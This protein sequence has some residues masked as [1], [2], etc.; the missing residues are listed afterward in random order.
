[1]KNNS[2]GVVGGGGPLLVGRFGALTSPPLNPTLLLKWSVSGLGG[3]P[4]GNGA[5]SGT[6]VLSDERDILLT[7][8]GCQTIHSLIH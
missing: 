8:S 4:S 6:P 1:M 2:A 3:R 5:V 7:W